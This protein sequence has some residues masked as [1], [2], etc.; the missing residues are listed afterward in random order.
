[1]EIVVGR[2][3]TPDDVEPLTW[4]LIERG[5]RETGADYLFAVSQHQMIGRMVAALYEGG[6]DL[7]MTPTLAD[8]PPP[9]GTYDDTGPDP[10]T[11]MGYARR[12]ATFTGPFNATGQPAISLPLQ[13]SS[14][15]LPIGIQFVAPIWR[16]DVLFRIASQLEQA[17]PWSDRR[18]T[19]IA[20]G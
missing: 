4:A 9:L 12:I 18:P 3:L 11:A 14:A 19:A 13:Q 8:V 20:A 2:K 1:V 7:I 17:H 10:M 5:R 6:Y 16:E 15:G